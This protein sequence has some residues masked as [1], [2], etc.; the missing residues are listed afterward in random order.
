MKQGTLPLINIQAK[1]KHPGETQCPNS[2]DF[3]ISWGLELV[4]IHGLKLIATRI[5]N[6]IHY[7]VSDANMTIPKF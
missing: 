6:Y 2:L 7:K 3:E 1:K 5:S 4:Y